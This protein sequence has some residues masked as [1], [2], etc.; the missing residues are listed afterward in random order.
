MS[1]HVLKLSSIMNNHSNFSLD[2]EKL[3]IY[4]KHNHNS[5][6][7]NIKDI[8][9]IVDDLNTLG[10]EYEVCDGYIQTQARAS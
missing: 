10:I 2:A 7:N 5:S 6:Y 3:K 9:S 4:H 8:V 1:E